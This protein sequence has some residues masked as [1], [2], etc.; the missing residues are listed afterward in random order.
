MKSAGSIPARAGEP[1]SLPSTGGAWAVYPRACGGTAAGYD[2]LNR[3]PGLSP[4]VRG[5]RFRYP[6]PA[7]PGR[8]IPARA[9]EPLR[10]TIA[11]TAYP[12]YPRACGGTWGFQPRPAP[13]WG[14][15]PRVR[16]N[17]PRYRF[18]DDVHRSI[19]ARAGE[20]P[21]SA[22]FQLRIQVYPRACGGTPVIIRGVTD[23]A[24]SIP[25]RAG[26]PVRRRD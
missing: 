5:N 25:A 21:I 10:V 13:L 6:P 4:R 8:S 15:S 3:L 24:R 16:G 23:L 26:E 1:V 7:G 19:P 18:V 22:P 20:P 12:V 14:L 9:G 2:S 17:L 11:S